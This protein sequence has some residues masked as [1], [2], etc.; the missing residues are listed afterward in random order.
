MPTKDRGPETPSQETLQ[1]RNDGNAHTEPEPI[2]VQQRTKPTNAPNAK[3]KNFV[4]K[5]QP[6]TELQTSE[7]NAAI[8]L[9]PAAAPHTYELS[10]NAPL[11]LAA[12]RP[13]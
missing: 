13:G 2:N 4:A 12:E 3:G 10:T 9:K 7:L 11:K 1:Y 5:Q 8:E 6:A